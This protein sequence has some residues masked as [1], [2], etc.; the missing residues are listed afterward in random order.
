MELKI[1]YAFLAVFFIAGS[2]VEYAL[3]Y[4]KHQNYYKIKDTFSSI[5]LMLAGLV[6]DM[7]M[8][9]LTIYG[10]IKL[11]AYALFNLGYDWWSWILCFVIWDFCFYCK[12]Y[13]EHNVR[14]MW[15]IHVNHHSSP[16]MN[17]STSLR[18]GV[19]KGIYRYF[20]Y[21]PIILLGFPL[22]MLIIIYG[23]GKLWAFFSH[24]QKLGNWGIL[25]KFLIT[26]LHHAVHHSCN[27]QNLNKNFGETLIIWDKLFGSFQKNKGNLI[28]GIHE[29]VDHSSFYKTVMHEFENMA[30][31]VKN[32]KNFKERLL[33]IFGKPGWNK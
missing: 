5:R 3:T 14:F 18:S 16:H 11:S 1:F 28:Y 13:T 20:F 26:P 33:Y 10:L 23:I 21:I 8:K 7:G 19:F 24:S 22:E 17:L 4:K 2:F 9:I 32:A 25:E 31:D 27:E 30:N 6:F 12:H 15:A 29:E